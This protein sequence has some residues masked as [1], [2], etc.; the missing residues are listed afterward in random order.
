[1]HRKNY[2]SI[3]ER[4]RSYTQ[5]RR[6]DGQLYD[7]DPGCVMVRKRIISTNDVKTYDG[8]EVNCYWI[9]CCICN[10][11][12]YTKQYHHVQKALLLTLSGSLGCVVFRNESYFMMKSYFG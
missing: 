5:A 7:G 9:N 11:L 8:C 12:I 2:C 1:M 6:N 4:S 3:E 10:I